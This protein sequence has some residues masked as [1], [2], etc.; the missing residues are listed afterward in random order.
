MKRRAFMAGL[1]GIA[2]PAQAQQPGAMRRIGILHP[3]D[4][5]L[6]GYRTTAFLEGVYASSGLREKS[7]E[8]RVRVAA[9]DLAK[10][11]GLAAELAG[12]GVDLLLAVS[13]V[14][15]RAARAAMHSVP[16]VALDL[17][18]DPMA[19][20]WIA[21]LARPGGN[22]TGIFL[23]FP[24]VSAKCLQ[25][26]AEALGATRIAV[27][28]DPATGRLQLDSVLTA[29]QKLG[30]A[31]RVLEVDGLDALKSAFATAARERIQSALLL[32]SPV[33]GV[34]TRA[35]AELAIHHRLATITL[36]PEFA[37]DGGM[38]AYG[39]DLQALYRQAGAIAGHLLR[40]ADPGDLPVERP[41]QLRFVINLKTAEAL[42]IAL[43][44]ATLAR[45]DE[46]IE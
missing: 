21:S 31:T 27:I 43:P 44:T 11:P 29:A 35:A 19:N 3:G 39:P 7:I 40:G 22:L 17:E 26:L 13:P 2:L 41:T 30:L 25:I 37:Q 36:F 38:M 12:E 32:S 14:A 15:V 10:M 33:I 9:G 23:D 20:G 5:P 6:T 8:I 1:L 18:S 28:W 42:G 24:D 46:V 45:A 34:H 16:I 4:L